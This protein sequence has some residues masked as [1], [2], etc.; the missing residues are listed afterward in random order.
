MAA[1]APLRYVLPHK[2]DAYDEKYSTKLASGEG[3]FRQVDR[4]LGP[5]KACSPVQLLRVN[6]LKRYGEFGDLL[7]AHGTAPT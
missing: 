2:R 4:D 1:Y 6:A 7:H 3:F 5:Q